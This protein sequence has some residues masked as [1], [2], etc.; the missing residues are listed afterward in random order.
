MNTEMVNSHKY[1]C[2]HLNNKLDW[3]ENA[4]YRKR[5]NRPYQLRRLRSFGVQGALL[6][7]FFFD[8][9][10]ASA[11]FYGVVPWGSSITT[12]DKKRLDKLIKKASSVLGSGLNTVQVVRERRAIAML[13]SLM[14]N[15]SHPMQDTLS[16]ALESSFSDTDTS[17][18]HWQKSFIWGKKCSRLGQRRQM[19]WK[20]S[21]RIHLCETGM[22]VFEQ[23]RWPPTL[24]ITHL[25][26]TTEFPPQML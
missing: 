17:A 15:S 22:A 4:L 12:A 14:E 13:L 11:I 5:S 26:Y 20:T 8:S 24:L 7:T 2:V 23:Q 19:V 25:Q 1:L 18:V 9:V 10:V 21:K 16:D 6:R 3:T